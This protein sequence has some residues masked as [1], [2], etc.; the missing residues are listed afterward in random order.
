MGL[1]DFVR[2]KPEWAKLSP[3]LQEKAEGY[4]VFLLY[5]RKYCVPLKP[6][7]KK[8]CGISRQGDT[9]VFKRG[10]RLKFNSMLQSIADSMYLQVRDTVG[11]EVT[12]TLSGQLNEFL[13]NRFEGA[14]GSVV[15]E[16]LEQGLLPEHEE[17]AT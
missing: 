16:Q 14:I 12:R 15:S 13:E 4:I 5:G 11:A 9:L 3:Y 7:M 10:D 1:M 17:E 6:E 2:E 8:V